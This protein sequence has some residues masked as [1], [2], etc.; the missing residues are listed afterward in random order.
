MDLKVTVRR[1]SQSSE[2]PLWERAEVGLKI[3][4]TPKATPWD[5]GLFARIIKEQPEETTY[6]RL[7]KRYAPEVGRSA[8][9]VRPKLRDA[10]EHVDGRWVRKASNA[11]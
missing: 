6:A 9:T 4:S 10:L 3:A 1:A 11:A 7:S 8:E 2:V 5:E